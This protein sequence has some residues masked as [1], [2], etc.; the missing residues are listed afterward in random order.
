MKLTT[1]SNLILRLTSEAIPVHP[2]RPSWHAQG[3]L[4][5][6]LAWHKYQAWDRTLYL[7]VQFVSQNNVI[8]NHTIVKTLKLVSPYTSVTGGG[9]QPVTQLLLVGAMFLIL[10]P[11][12]FIWF[13]AE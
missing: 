3:Q 5:S 13:S 9:D 11:F 8:L 7:R 10:L 2:H 4:L 1:T 6:Y 12:P